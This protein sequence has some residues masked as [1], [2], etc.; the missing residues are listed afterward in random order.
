[1]IFVTVGT[2]EQPFN[3]LIEEVD[4]LK[5][6]GIIEEEVIIQRGYST[7]VPK[8]CKY[9]DLISYEEMDKYIHDANIVITH[10][11]PASFLAPIS[12]GKIPIVVPRQKVYNE[13]V[14]DHQLEFS[15]ELVKRGFSII[16]IE[17]I[18]ELGKTIL[19]FNSTKLFS[20]N[21]HTNIFCNSFENELIKLFE[22]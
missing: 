16:L 3:R 7:Y 12:I 8:Y 10:G 5:G 1:M 20:I 17:N 18:N 6:E 19:D 13:H 2:H 22:E 21:K 11:G 15:R 14:N 4:R 9:Y